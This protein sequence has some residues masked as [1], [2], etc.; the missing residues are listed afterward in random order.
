MSR[1]SSMISTSFRHLGMMAI[2]FAPLGITGCAD[3]SAR[4]IPCFAGPE[5]LV[6]IGT[7]KYPIIAT[8]TTERYNGKKYGRIEFY[9]PGRD[10]AFSV[11]PVNR[12]FSPVGL[13]F[14][15]KTNTKRNERT[16]TLYV[17]DSLEGKV[18]ILEVCGRRLTGISRAT[19]PL[20]GKEKPNGIAVFDDGMIYVT[21]M[22]LRPK[23]KDDPTAVSDSTLPFQENSVARYHPGEKSWETVLTGF[24][25]ANG[26]AKGPEGKS[27]LVCSYHSRQIWVFQR[28]PKSG[29]LKNE[30]RQVLPL[31]LPFHPDNLKYV[32]DGWYD[33]CGQKG[34]LTA[35]LQLFTRLPFSTGGWVRF[36]WDG[37][38]LTS[39]DRSSLLK[40]HYLAPSTALEAGGR[41]YS[42][43]P[44]NSGVFTR[45]MPVG[46]A[47]N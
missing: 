20:G 11:V 44:L 3:S 14:V 10:A 9:E 31:K 26:I 13:V 15:S 27:L 39:Q 25:G 16:G 29:L 40:G 6:N 4:R 2:V 41:V 12:R 45:P 42:G 23:W 35:G 7:A 21:G 8:G 37:K 32:G 19:K 22:G 18:E 38:N 30:G 24:N 17:T 1:I 47:G 28:E 34:W 5:D 46:S 36:H 33:V 43:Q